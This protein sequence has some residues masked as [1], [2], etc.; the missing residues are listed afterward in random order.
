MSDPSTSSGQA[1]S[2]SSGR[3]AAR[4][5]FVT[6]NGLRF[7]YIEYAGDGDPPGPADAPPIVLLHGLAS[8][9]RWWVL[10]GPMLGR[11]FRVVALDQRGHGESA[12]P[13]SGYD[14]ATVAG[15]LA[16]FVDE[17]GLKRPV[18]VGHSWGGNVALEYAA[19]HPDAVAG[20]VLVDGGF[21]E[22]QARPDMTWERAER[23]LAPPDLAHLTPEQLVAG[24]KQWEL[25]SIWSDEIESALLGNFAV[26][27]DGTIRPH[28]SRANHMQVVRALWDQ[29]PSQLYER[30]RSPVLFVLAE[31]A[32]GGRTR[33][34]MQMKREAIA[35]AE[36]SLPDCRVLWMQDTIH[37]IP[38]HRPDELA[39]AI[40]EFTTGLRDAPAG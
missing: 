16:A 29:R 23:E 19:T 21:M 28:L 7:H 13:D 31:R 3:D 1:P 20:I 14:F 6:L 24:A 15:D 10:V 40:G 36:R 34:W 30:V 2:T 25:G 18:V 8:N 11:R 37:D 9:A 26:A 4:S 22:P 39:Q 33:D 27:E 38:L 5:A 35:R 32:G 17:L 12:A